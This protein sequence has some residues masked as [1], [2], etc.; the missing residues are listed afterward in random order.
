MLRPS[1]PCPQDLSRDDGDPATFGE[2][3]L[4][5]DGDWERE[6]REDG[7][8]KREASVAS[9]VPLSRSTPHCATA[10]LVAATISAR[11][12]RNFAVASPRASTAWS[13][14]SVTTDNRPSRSDTRTR[15]D[16][17]SSSSARSFSSMLALDPADVASSSDLSRSASRSMLSVMRL[18]SS[19]CCCMV[20]SS[21]F[22]SDRHDA[23]ARNFSSVAEAL[24]FISSMHLSSALFLS[25]A[26][27][28][29]SLHDTYDV[30]SV[31]ISD[32]QVCR[33]SFSSSISTSSFSAVALFRSISSS[34][35]RH[36]LR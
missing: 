1:C 32:E 14:S 26:S 19:L 15:L 31:S 6:G 24:V 29:L 30:F 5:E 17:A 23:T 25:M 2:D 12:L 36:R 13:L 18:R 20:I 3:L 7:E 21:R 33:A 4:R 35:S 16:S 22:A 9:N 28:S 11:S 10:K 27:A 8:S 34:R